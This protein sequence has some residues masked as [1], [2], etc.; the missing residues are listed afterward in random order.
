MPP[1]LTDAEIVA[2]LAS[3]AQPVPGRPDHAVVAV[4][5]VRQADEGAVE[6]VERWV[7]AH[8][9][10]MRKPLVSHVFS[11]PE[12]VGP[13]TGYVIPRAALRP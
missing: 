6:A 8:G 5:Q 13:V 10:L 11:Q 3:L 1:P 9:R 2:L 7:T 12:Q 4:A